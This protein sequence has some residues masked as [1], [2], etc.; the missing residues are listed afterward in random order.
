VDEAEAARFEAVLS[1]SGGHVEVAA[2]RA[3]YQAE[4][5]K[6]FDPEAPALK[7]TDVQAERKRRVRVS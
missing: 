4:G 2:R 7:T 6:R 3:E 5:W 1:G